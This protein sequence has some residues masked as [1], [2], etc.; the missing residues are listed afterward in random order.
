MGHLF[1]TVQKAMK[2]REGNEDARFDAISH[3]FRQHEQNPEKL[4]MR[5]I[6]TQ[7]LAAVGAGSDTV[8]CALQSLIYHMS[9]HPTAWKSVCDEI[10]DAKASGRC[11][12]RIVSFSDAQQLW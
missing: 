5:E 1:N 4:T 7:A 8:S 10:D 11:L 12:D 2:E 6:H 3:W 9:R